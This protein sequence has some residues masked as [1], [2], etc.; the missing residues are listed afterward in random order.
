MA[1]GPR[2]GT[3]A[4]LLSITILPV[5]AAATAT[6]AALPVTLSLLPATTAVLA[7]PLATGTISF[8]VTVATPENYPA[9]RWKI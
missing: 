7:F 4:A 8:P 5:P 6:L 1:G 3:P 9:R 2:P